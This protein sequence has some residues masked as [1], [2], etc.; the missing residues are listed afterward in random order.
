MRAMI[1]ALMLLVGGPVLAQAAGTSLTLKSSAFPSGGAIPRQYTAYGENRSPPLSWRPAAGAKAYALTV[2]DP[3]AK[4]KTFTHWLV[5]NIP[6]SATSLPE[7]G[8]AGVVEG[9]NDT[10]RIGYSGPHPPSGVHHYHFRIMA[11]DAPLTLPAGADFPALT[12][13]TQGHV[14]GEGE[15]VGTF[16]K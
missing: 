9:R 11:L 13:A 7:G 6:G 2:R 16:A 4:P 5:W 1:L 15:L 10:G 8:L 14:I 12:K 3:D